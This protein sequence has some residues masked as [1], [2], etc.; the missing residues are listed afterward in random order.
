MGS[1][2]LVPTAPYFEQLRQQYSTAFDGF[3][4]HPSV[5]WLGIPVT[6]TNA[7]LV[8]LVG[9]ALSALT[10]AGFYSWAMMMALWLLYFSVVSLAESTSFYQYGWESQ[11]LETGFLCVFLCRLSLLPPWDGCSEH[12]APSVP[13]LW[14]LRWLMFRISIGAGLIK[15]RGGSCWA[16]KTCLHYHFETQPIPSPLSFVF[17]FLPK[18]VLSRAVDL[19]LFVQLYTSWAV[20]V[21]GWTK[22]LRF[23]RRAAGLT[24]AAF[25]VNIALSGNLGFLNHLTV[26]PA[27]ACLDDSCWPRFCRPAGSRTK[28]SNPAPVAR[29]L[30]DVVL[31]GTI[32]VLSLPVVANLLQLDGHQVMNSSFGRFRLVNTYGAFGSVGER[33]FEPIVSVSHDGDVWHALDFPCKPGTVTRRPCF[34]AP[35]HY[36]LDWNIWFIGFP[37]H[38]AMLERREKWLYSLVR[39]L[40]QRDELALSLL[41]R[42]AAEGPGFHLRDVPTAPK[43]ARVD[44]YRYEMSQPLWRLLPM[45]LG[46]SGPVVWWNAT[47]KEPLIPAVQL[48]GSGKL[49][50]AAVR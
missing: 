8:S 19:D 40:L 6:D 49:G 15:I 47:Y 31:V 17:H 12:S 30:I 28:G 4:K 25:M 7:E 23:V 46:R 43:Y 22:Q 38:S 21:P 42:S 1:S 32:A 29:T 16:A 5:F 37:P 10:V 45:A 9:M 14:L 35:Y 3:L 27:L 20:L 39:K 44:M 18:P 2:G 50:R 36:R 26:I 11:L 24:Q 48:H 41:D 34:C 13:V 33:R